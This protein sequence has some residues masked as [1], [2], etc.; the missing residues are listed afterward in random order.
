M[1]RLFAVASDLLAKHP[2]TLLALFALSGIVLADHF[3]QSS[4]TYGAA[5][6]LCVVVGLWFPH[7]MLACLAAFCVFALHHSFRWE[8]T[9]GHPLRSL[10]IGDEG[11][12][13]EA[14]GEFLNGPTVAGSAL[15]QSVMFRA[16]QI[17]I[18]STSQQITGVTDLKLSGVVFARRFVAKGGAWKVSGTLHLFRQPLN[19]TPHDMEEFN[20]RA[21]VVGLL[22]ASALIHDSPSFSLKLWLLE[23]AERCR[24]WIAEQVALGLEDDAETTAI[25]QTMA[26]GTSGADTSELE[27]PFVESGTL[28]VFAVSGLHVGLIGVIGWIV[29]KSIRVRWHAALFVLIPL[30]IGYAFV[31]G[32]RPSAARAACMMT[33]MMMAP[34]FMRRGRAVNALG[35]AALLLWVVDTNELYDAGFQLSFFVL[36]SIAALAEPIAKPFQT[37]AA[38][39]EFLPVELASWRQRFAA[40]I[41]E[42]FVAMAGTSVAAWLGSAPLMLAW[43]KT[44]TPIGLLAN[45]VLVPLAF[46]ALSCIALSL[47]ASGVGLK[48]MQTGFNQ[49]NWAVA[50]CMT[51]SAS[52]F[53]SVP[54]GHMTVSQDLV[55]DDGHTTLVFPALRPAESAA[56]L[57]A[58]GR[59]WML[60]CGTHRSYLR[61]VE[62]MLR[63]HGV[64]EIDG[65]ILS[66]SDADHAGGG[67]LLF[68]RAPV[69][70]LIIP[71]H[72]PWQ[73]DSRATTL[74]TLTRD[75]KAAAA[76]LFRA[77]AGE[78]FDLT[79]SV[80][81]HV[82][83][84]TAQ[85]I[86]DKADDRAMV[87]RIEIGNVR[88][89]W[90]NDA[91]LPTEKRLLQRMLKRDLRATVLWRGQHASEVSA[92]PEF[93]AAVKP[94]VVIT[95]NDSDDPAEKVP[96]LLD[97]YCKASRVHLLNLQECGQVTLRVIGEGI[98][99]HTHV[100]SKEFTITP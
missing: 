80:S 100:S 5:G 30:V 78:V 89:L 28:H 34:L 54:F 85:D 51:W 58:D 99:F 4:A 11:V 70:R 14:L 56:L 84:P 38:L 74:W 77:Q 33:L 52:L 13:V 3:P 46:V 60:D 95:S 48:Q 1:N 15:S 92:T 98:Q 64:I 61:I 8:G 18:P 24:G 9:F 65:V 32:W 22:S 71:M 53:A 16:R 97:E 12:A 29:L 47:L 75:P 20:L 90:V 19:P 42:W 72:E 59:R 27:K 73:L 57:K 76:E 10:K 7:R 26:L 83:Y 86:A 2:L 68:A 37:W 82:L 36:W 55:Q 17:R 21:G 91:G 40:T 31:T 66:H 45:L 88:V 87:A 96:A 69:R 93:L 25:L 62:P 49:A 35:L 50:K 44:I 41:R 6:L 81:M 23:R 63:R 79:S 94:K 39:D 43:F 67:K